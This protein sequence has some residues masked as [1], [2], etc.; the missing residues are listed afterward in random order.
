[1]RTIGDRIRHALS[2]EI[3][4]LALIIPLGSVVFGM[5]AEDIGIVGVVSATIA[6]AWNYL[7]NLGFDHVMQ[8]KLGTTQKTVAIRVAHA[9]LFELGLLLVLMPFI[10]WYLDISIIH[11]LVMDVSF[12]LFYVVYAFVFNWCYDRLF[13]LP[14]WQAENAAK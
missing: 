1:M 14:E 8:R 11:A 5:P 13:P 4:G 12:A 9:V 7:Y 10:A 2:F 3:I 6:T